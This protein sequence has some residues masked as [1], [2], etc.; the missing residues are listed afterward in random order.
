MQ[1]FFKCFHPQTG[2]KLHFVNL[3]VLLQRCLRP[4]QF[5]SH[6]K[7]SPSCKPSEVGWST[8]WGHTGKWSSR[9][10]PWK[11]TCVNYIQQQKVRISVYIVFDHDISIWIY[12]FLMWIHLVYIYIYTYTSHTF[13]RRCS[14]IYLNIVILSI[15]SLTELDYYNE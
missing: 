15:S 7:I 11:W 1:C 4:N 12:L 8:A 2:T 13:M 9:S 3:H 10:R 6:V 14:F 5:M